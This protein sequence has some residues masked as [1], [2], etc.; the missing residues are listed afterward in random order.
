MSIMFVELV[1]SFPRTFK[2]LIP[3]KG[4]LYSSKWLEY[5]TLYCC[6]L[7]WVVDKNKP[8][9]NPFKMSLKYKKITKRESVLR[10]LCTIL[11]LPV[12]FMQTHLPLKAICHK[13]IL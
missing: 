3:V 4:T 6:R 11:Y 2:S 9:L 5:K 8:E 12:S 1:G 13:H 7:L 10:L